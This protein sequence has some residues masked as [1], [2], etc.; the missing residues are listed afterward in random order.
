M[1]VACIGL[2]T[3]GA[4]MARILARGGHAVVGY[5]VDAVARRRFVA[6]GGAVAE[7]AA[8]AVAAA[9]VVLTML[10]EGRHVRDALLGPGGVARHLRSN[11]LVL[12]MSTIDPRESDAIRADLASLGIAMVDAPVGRTSEHAIRG[13]LLVM[14]GGTPADLER[15][16]PLL[17]LVGERTIDCGGPGTGIR[18]KIVN[19]FMSI[20]LNAL[21]AEALTLA[22][23]S[24]LD[25]GRTL[26]V[27][28]GT[29]AGQGHFTTTYPAKVLAGDLSPAFQLRLARKDLA[30]GVAFAATVGLDSRLGAAA[31]TWY[32]EAMGHGRGGEDWTAILAEARDSRDE[33]M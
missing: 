15:V 24:G 4:P 26:E 16:R 27:L 31:L 19:N 9:D 29:P 5:D 1:N 17:E 8:D 30:I 25:L 14:A 2:G 33:A 20:A 6:G 22:E 21:S 3:M 28:G 12:E 18:M 11:A 10:P 7:T 13:E 23:S 32:D